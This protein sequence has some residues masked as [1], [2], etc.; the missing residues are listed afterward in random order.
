MIEPEEDES[1]LKITSCNAFSGTLVIP[2]SIGGTPVVTI[3]AGAFDSRYSRVTVPESVIEIEDGAFAK[4]TTLVCVGGSS[5]SIWASENGYTTA[6]TF[7]SISW[8]TDCLQEFDA[9]QLSAGDMIALPTMIRYGYTLSGWNWDADHTQPVED[10]AVMPACDLTL[11]ALW[12]VK[13]EPLAVF[14]EA[15]IWQ[16][17]GKCQI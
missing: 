15:L 16:V 2:A 10:D 13:D 12:M 3:G 4:G 11:Y 6:E 1:Y 14:M 8:Q 7:W 5:A 17:K 9:V